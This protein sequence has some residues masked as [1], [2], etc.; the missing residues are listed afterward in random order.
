MPNFMKSIL[1]ITALFFAKLAFG[2]YRVDPNVQHEFDS[3]LHRQPAEMQ[4]KL[5]TETFDDGFALV[6]NVKA[7]TL[8]IEDFSPFT[9]DSSIKIVIVDPKT[10]KEV[11]DSPKDTA[12]S[13]QWLGSKAFLKKDTLSIRSFFGLFSGYGFSIKIIGNKSIGEYFEYVRRSKIY[14][15][16]LT[17]HKSPEIRVKARP[18]NVVLSSLPKKTGDVFYGKVTLVTEP[19]Y[20]DNEEFAKG[21]IHT[22]SSITYLFRCKVAE[23]EQLGY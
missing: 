5:S 13:N 22:R 19:F 21:F 16:K 15:Q 3:L 6:I 18:E 2:Q 1:L 7:D 8:N 12:I 20:V 23:Q 11:P 4:Q 9:F 17:S 14:R 10:G